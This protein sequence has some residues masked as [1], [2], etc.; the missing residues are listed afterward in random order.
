MK[1]FVILSALLASSFLFS[2][3]TYKFSKK[4]F[5]EFK[6]IKKRKEFKKNA[7]AYGSETAYFILL[8]CQAEAH[9]LKIKDL[10]LFNPKTKIKMHEDGIRAISSGC[11]GEANRYR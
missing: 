8:K 11:R 6:E 5:K 4:E 9:N 3:E 1:N 2:Q 10:P 7:N